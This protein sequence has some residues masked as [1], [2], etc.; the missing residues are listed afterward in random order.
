MRTYRRDRGVLSV[1]TRGGKMTDRV[2][3]HQ[4]ALAG[5]WASGERRYAMGCGGA[6]GDLVIAVAR[7]S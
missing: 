2:V 6:P 3:S 4:F 7:Q 5:L 1:E